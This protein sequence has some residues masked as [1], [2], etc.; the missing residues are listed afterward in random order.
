MNYTIVRDDNAFSPRENDNLGTIAYV[1]SRYELGDHHSS[2]DEL[3]DV[4]NNK[5][6]IVLPVYAYIHG[7]IA[8]NT[9]GFSC[10]WDSGQSGC[11]YVSKDKVREW[12]NVKRISP[13]LFNKVLK[14]LVAEVEE[15]NMYLNGDVYGYIIKDNDGNE[16][17]S[18]WG[19]IGEDSAKEAAE[20]SFRF[21]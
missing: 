20:E 21:F 13:K 17:D 10:P 18:C 11:I 2:N 15:Y 4:I 1:S 3:D 5:N 14:A 6:N 19:F 12:F 8:L 7:G 9:T 16:V